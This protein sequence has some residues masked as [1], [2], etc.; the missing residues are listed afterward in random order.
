MLQDHR[1]RRPPARRPRRA[2]L[3]RRHAQEMQRNW[4]GRSEGA[5]VDFAVDG[6]DDDDRGLHHAPRH[7]LRRAPTWCSRPST[8][9]STSITTPEQRARGRR[10]SRARSRK[11]R[12]RAH[13]EAAEERRPA[14]SPARIAINPVNGEQIP[15]WIADYVLA[16]YGTGAIMARA[17]RTTSATHAFATHVRPADRRGRAAGGGVDVQAAAY[18]DDGVARATAASSTG[19]TTSRREGDDDRRGSRAQQLRRARACNYKLR[20]WVFSRQRYWGEPFPIV[21]ARRTAPSKPVAETRAAAACCRELDDFK[22]T[23]RR[24]AAARAR[25]ASW[26]DDHDGDGSAG[27]RETNTMPQWAGSCWYYLRFLDPHERRERAG[28]PGEREVLDAGRSLRRRRRARGPAPALRALLAQGALRPRPRVDDGAVPAAGPPGHDP[29]D[30]VPRRERQVR[31]RS[32]RRAARRRMRTSRAT[33]DAVETKL[34]KMSKSQVNVVNPDDMCARVRRRRDAALRDVHGPAR[35]RRRVGDRGRR[36]HAR[37]LDRVW[38]LLRRRRETDDAV[39]KVSEDAPTDNKELERALHAAIKKVTHAVDDLRFNTAIAEMMVFVNEATKARRDPARVVRDVRAVLSPFA[40]HLAEELWQRLGHTTSI[41]YE[42]WPAYD[43]AKLA[44]DTMTIG[45]PGQRQA[46]RRDRGAGRRERGDD[47]RGREGR[48]EGRSRSSPARRS[49]ARS[50]SRAG[51][52][53]S[54]CEHD[55]TRCMR[56]AQG[57][58]REGRVSHRREHPVRRGRRAVRDR[59][60][61]CRQARRVRVPDGRGRR[62]LGRRRRG[63][64]HSSMRVARPA[65][66]SSSW[67]TRPMRPMP[68]ASAPPRIYSWPS[69]RTK[70]TT[71]SQRRSRPRRPTRNRR[72]RSRL[73]PRSRRRR[74]SR[75]ARRASIS[76]DLGVLAPWR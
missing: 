39:A 74:R 72:R 36:G 55:R 4:I 60:L 1:V 32:R 44:R 18:T 28:R 41:A 63:D 25:D 54:W 43:E 14:C 40:P 68:R 75:N 70:S 9:S 47:P 66:C 17:R 71:T 61:R 31:R 15:I 8:R 73:A 49:S 65:S 45:D 64:Q 5:D 42:P 35:G 20:D 24:R 58:V 56:A 46:A 12:P 48:R 29:R 69:S 34:E 37:F 38:R 13:D 53:T 50:T 16:S 59:R 52:S 11:E 21:R 7:A 27:A 19:S 67:S 10:V 2:R 33:D 30:V 6:H 51:S 76:A 22:P 3:A 57:A 62:Q 26:L 23:R